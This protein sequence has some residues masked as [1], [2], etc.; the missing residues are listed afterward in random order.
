[1]TVS[2][3]VAAVG[4]TVQANARGLAPNGDYDLQVCGQDAVN[5]STDCA[6]LDTVATVAGAKGTLT[7]PIEVVAPPTPCPCVVAA[8]ATTGN[9]NP[10]TAPISIEGVSSSTAA[11]ISPPQTPRPN[12]V[13]VD[14]KMGSMP[15]AAWFGLSGT[16]TVALTLLNNGTEPAR[17][18]GIFATIGSTPVVSRQLPG[19]GV[20]QQETYTVPVKIP[21]LTVGNGTLVAHID[22]GNGQLDNFK[23]PAPHWPW[24]LFIV[25][26]IIIQLILLKVHNKMRRRREQKNPPVPPSTDHEE[27]MFVGEVVHDGA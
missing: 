1:M 17:S 16:Q 10:L 8:F 9:A 24:G 3:A 25:A 12:I 26:F 2:P 19:L 20:G 4:Q 6:A 21:A 14:A 18:I 13:V 15:L 27:T 7:M 22:R 23:V 11:P 5:G